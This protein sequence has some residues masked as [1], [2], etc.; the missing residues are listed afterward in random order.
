MCHA[1]VV[2]SVASFLAGVGMTLLVLKK[3]MLYRV[4]EGSR[5]RLVSGAYPSAAATN[6][7][8]AYEPHPQRAVRVVSVRQWPL[9]LR[10]QYFRV[11]NSGQVCC[12]TPISAR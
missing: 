1:L 3:I 10:R 9:G 4:V 8:A 12:A 2:L 11:V 6:Y 7:A 5:S